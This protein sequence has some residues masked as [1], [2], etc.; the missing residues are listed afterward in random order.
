VIGGLTGAWAISTFGFISAA[1]LP[2][3]FVLY[4][5]GAPIRAHSKYT[6]HIPASMMKKGRDEEMQM[7]GSEMDGMTR[8]T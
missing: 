7:Q 3:P 1:L 8:G 2:I 6:P 5:F 4:K